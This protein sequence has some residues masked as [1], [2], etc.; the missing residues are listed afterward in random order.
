[1]PKTRIVLS[2]VLKPVTDIRMFGKLGRSLAKLPGFEIHLV[3][4]PAVLPENEPEICFYPLSG[5]RRLSVKRLLAQW[6]YYKI[7]H[8]VKPQVIIV[9]T[10]ELLPVTF[11]YAVLFKAE[12]YYD[13][14]ENYFKNITLQPTYPAWFRPLLAY[15]LRFLEKLA[16]HHIS[17]FFLAE[18]SYAEELTF[19]GK[20][21]TV[22]E[23]KYLPSTKTGIKKTFPIKL[24]L[25]Q[26]VNLLYS[27]TIAEVY[28]IWE[29]IGLTE[30]L[31]RLNPNIRLILIGFCA[32]NHTLLQLKE[33]IRNKPYITLT[34]GESLVPHEEI[35]E[36]IA[37]SQVGLLPYRPNPSTAHCMPT[38]L[39]EYLGNGLPMLLP[40]NPIWNG[41][42]RQSQ[43]GF[44]INFQD[45][46]AAAILNRLT[47]AVFY[48]KGIPRDV[49][50]QE[51]EGK[52]LA[53]FRKKVINS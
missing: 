25:S 32:Q 49:F 34:G 7:L 28:G 45:P 23:N 17:H 38:R 52:L 30:K 29:A 46:D 4:Q 24:D 21:Y 6:K 27:G 12:I 9:S 26:P 15:P 13:V 5:F 42:V 2:S 48:P 19:L 36:A 3:G 53:I 16:A 50:W 22:L 14:Q 39:F 18:K 51:E 43:A 41:P 8:K 1:M 40:E 31:H 35:L 11:L 20:N 37:T 44:P 10:P 47:E 33:T